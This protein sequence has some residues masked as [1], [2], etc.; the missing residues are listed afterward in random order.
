M[1]QEP[2]IDIEFEDR[3]REELQPAPPRRWQADRPG[4]LTSPDQVPWG[5]PFGTPG[6]DT[7]YALKLASGAG[8]ELEPHED[9]GNVERAMVHLMASRA[10][11]FGRAPTNEDLQ[12]AMLLLGLAGPDEVPAAVASQLSKDRR[13]WA[14]RAA[15]NSAVARQMVSRITPELLEA[16]LEDVRHRLALGEIPLAR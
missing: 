8:M 12:F 7:G 9:R 10:S 15:R 13:Y 5:G 14:P 4:D 6:P 1:G 3:P 11:R 2:N 16:S